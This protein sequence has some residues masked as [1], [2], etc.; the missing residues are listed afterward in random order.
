MSQPEEVG[1]ARGHE[2]P[3]AVEGIGAVSL[4][5][6]DMARAVRYYR[7]LGFTIGQGGEQASFT[8]SLS[9]YCLYPVDFEERGGPWSP[10]PWRIEVEA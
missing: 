10:S 4:V 7:A 5:T 1:G 8:S 6:H 3:P 9:E 2:G